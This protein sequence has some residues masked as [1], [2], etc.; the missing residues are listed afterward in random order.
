MLMPVL[1]SGHLYVVRAPDDATVQKIVDLY[2]GLTKELVGDLGWYCSSTMQT[3]AVLVSGKHVPIRNGVLAFNLLTF[4]CFSHL[5][6]VGPTPEYH[7]AQ[8]PNPPSP[9][10]YEPEP[11]LSSIEFRCQHCR[12]WQSVTLERIDKPDVC[13][14][15]VVVPKEERQPR[16]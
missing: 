8:D 14:E 15:C 5:L 13:T 16:R 11:V 2:L 12:V 1:C 3:Y 4:D 9:R 7:A 6:L 10:P